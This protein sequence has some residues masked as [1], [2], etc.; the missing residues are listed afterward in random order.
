MHIYDLDRKPIEVTDL[1][2][3]IQIT[4]EYKD[5]QH[6]DPAFANLDQLLQTYWSDIHSKLLQ[7]QQ[8]LQC[9]F[10]RAIQPNYNSDPTLKL[11]INKAKK[12]G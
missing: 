1:P 12:E 11:L 6:D 4:S 8:A 5:W 10:R 3:A 7:L 2:Q 9:P